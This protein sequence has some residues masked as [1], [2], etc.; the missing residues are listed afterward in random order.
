MTPDLLRPQDRPSSLV[1]HLLI[2]ELCLVL[3]LTLCPP[4][5]HVLRR[6]RVFVVN[7]AGLYPSVGVAVNSWALLI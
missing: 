5:L 6:I 2:Y 1:L 7:Y 3:L 4:L